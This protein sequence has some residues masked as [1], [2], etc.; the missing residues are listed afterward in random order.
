MLS[1]EA[2]LITRIAQ[3]GQ[4]NRRWR[5]HGG[6]WCLA[7]MIL[8]GC[9]TGDHQATQ[10][11]DL[12]PGPS[13]AAASSSAVGSISTADK[14]YLKA[15]AWKWI[16]KE[17]L[18]LASN[19]FYKC[20]GSWPDSLAD[21]ESNNLLLFEHRNP[22]GEEL[23]LVD[24]GV[25]PETL[26]QHCAWLGFD[27]GGI[28]IAWQPAEVPQVLAGERDYTVDFSK[29]VPPV[30]DLPAE[31]RQ[32]LLPTLWR[33]LV[34]CQVANHVMSYGARWCQLPGTWGQLALDTGWTIKT[35]LPGSFL[36]ERVG[37][38]FWYTIHSP[39]FPEPLIMA[40]TYDVTGSEDEVCGGGQAGHPDMTYEQARQL[41]GFAEFFRY[42]E[43]TQGQKPSTSASASQQEP[44]EVAEP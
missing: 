39:A 36:I 44:P 20:M 29:H 22:Q 32:R 40:N 41:P 19:L 28:R 10:N 17:D 21:F 35:D 43:K 9:G 33:S 18:A 7:L 14:A 27:E 2:F 4:L 26:A 24:T 42:S 3:L 16:L 34:E 23:V 11:P 31:E 6:A 13:G 15:N 1:K 8:T 37:D 30:L 5:L 12:T 25:S 38:T